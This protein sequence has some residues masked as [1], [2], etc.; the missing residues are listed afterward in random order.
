MAT[1]AL[2]VENAGRVATASSANLNSCLVLRFPALASC[3]VAPNPP[4]AGQSLRSVERWQEAKLLAAAGG[5]IV[6]GQ[7]KPARLAS[8]LGRTSRTGETDPQ[9]LPLG[10]M[11]AFQGITNSA[12]GSGRPNPRTRRTRYREI[13]PVE[14]IRPKPRRQDSGAIL[15]H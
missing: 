6:I 13:T 10:K 9:I 5:A 7:S 1:E 14:N 4:E 12:Y 15:D 11:S 3:T 8:A 2:P